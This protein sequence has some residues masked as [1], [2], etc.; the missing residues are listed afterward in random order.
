MAIDN[1]QTT[2]IAN[3]I[4]SLSLEL[5]KYPNITKDDLKVAFSVAEQLY[6]TT[7][8]TSKIQEIDTTSSLKP[9][10]NKR[11][12]KFRST[13]VIGDYILLSLLKLSK[14]YAEKK[15][16]D[17]TTIR[18]EY[19]KFIRMHEDGNKNAI[20][21]YSRK[22]KM[23]KDQKFIVQQDGQYSL[24]NKGNER[25][26][27]VFTSKELENL[28]PIINDEPPLTYDTTP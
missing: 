19:E 25:L 7:N 21:N 1:T 14:E 28:N 27:Y 16:F 17:Y 26:K 10:Q 3:L 23:M 5:K 4:T 18:M 20:L 6:F 11:Q 15:E 8:S 24:T 13:K 2:A 9:K 22:I 12:P